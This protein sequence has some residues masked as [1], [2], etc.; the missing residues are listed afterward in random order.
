VRGELTAAYAAYMHFNPANIA[1]TAPRSVYYAYDAT[2]GTYWA[3]ASFQPTKAALRSKPG[4]PAFN[5]LVNMQDG[6]STGLFTRA[7]GGPWLV[8]ADSF[9]PQCAIIEFFPKAVTTV[10]ALQTTPPT[11]MHC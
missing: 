10:W 3:M 1:G 2:T 5:M 8:Q 11:G 6:G 7:S 9:P 4:S